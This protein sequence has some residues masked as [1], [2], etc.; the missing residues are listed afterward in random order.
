MKKLIFIA[1]FGMSS[2]GATLPAFAGPN[3]Q[4]IEDGRKAKREQMAQERAV[5]AQL[6][7]QAEGKQQQH[8]DSQKQMEKMMQECAK[9]MKQD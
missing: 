8:P 4:L 5:Q 6:S 3:W 1:L 9:M 2:I 7:Q